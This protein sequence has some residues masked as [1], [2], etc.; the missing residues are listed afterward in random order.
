MDALDRAARKARESNSGHFV[1]LP[2]KTVPEVTLC[3]S[4]SLSSPK[5]AHDPDQEDPAGRVILP[6]SS[7]V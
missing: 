7:G 5:S 2:G 3:L 1:A 6:E 4:V